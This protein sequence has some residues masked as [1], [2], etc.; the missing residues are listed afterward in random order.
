MWE[1]KPK[2]IGVKATQSKCNALWSQV[3]FNPGFTE[4]RVIKNQ[5]TSLEQLEYS[6]WL[7]Q[8]VFHFHSLD[9]EVLIELLI[10]ITRQAVV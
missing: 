7:S 1:E 5:P 9:F 6:L 4:S 3:G 8:T 10:S 2:R